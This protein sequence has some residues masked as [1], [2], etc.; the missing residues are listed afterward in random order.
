MNLG[1]LLLVSVTL[2][3]SAASIFETDMPPYEGTHEFEA[4]TKELRLHE[5]PSTTSRTINTVKVSLGQRLPYDDTV[6]RTIQSGRIR[7]LAPSHVEGRMIGPVRRLLSKA[8][9]DYNAFRTVKIEVK[10]GMIIEYLQYRAEGT[11]FLRIGNNVVEAAQC[12]NEDNSIFK[13]E[14]EPK[15][16]L[17]IHVSIGKSSGWLLVT[18]ATAKLVPQQN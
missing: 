10:P 12:P 15:T 13:L 6:Y 2:L 16:E 8:Y 7:V 11:C 4:A 5:L 1:Y 14:T 3:Q 9:Y 17:W 18:D